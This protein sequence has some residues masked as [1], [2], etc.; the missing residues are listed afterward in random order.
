MPSQ[1]G[2]RGLTM[3]RRT[4]L[5]ATAVGLAMPAFIR[6]ASAA[7]P[8]TLISSRYPALDIMPTR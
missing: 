4:M 7:E 3:T 5:G 1:K 6:R 8:V 2:S